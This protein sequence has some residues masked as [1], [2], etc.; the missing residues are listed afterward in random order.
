MIKEA[1]LFASKFFLNIRHCEGGTTEV[2][3]CLQRI[4]SLRCAAFAMTL[5]IFCSVASAQESLIYDDALRGYK[6]ALNLFQQKNYVHAKKLFIEFIESP[7]HV[8]GNE[9]QTLKN[10]AR[11]YAAF[12][13]LEL[14]QPDAEKLLLDMAQ[15]YDETPMKRLGYYYMGKYYFREKNYAEA[16]IW[17]EKTEIADLSNEDI[18]EYK[19]QLAYCYFY[20]KKLTEAG[21]LFKEI[22]NIKNKY[23]YPA[24]YYYGYIAFGNKEFDDAL[25]SFERLKDSKVYE[26]IIPY[27]ISQ[28]YYFKKQYKELTEY[29]API[30]N[31]TDLKYY[32]ELN[33]ILGQA[34]FDQQKYDK[35]VR[36]L[37]IYITQTGKARK[38]D[39]YQ[40]GYAHYK[41][42]D[43]KEAILQFEQLD[44]QKDTLGQ[45]ALYLLADCYMKSGN[46]SSA[47]S[48]FQKAAQME[49]DPFIA[50]HALF[51]YGKLSY[52]QGFDSEAIRAL[53]Q[54]NEKY[55]NGEDAEEAKEL[56]SELFLN[57]R[58]FKEA[59]KVIESVKNP[60][61]KVKK[62]YQEVAYFRGLEHYN[63]KEFDEGI[64]MFDVSLQNPSN[65]SIKALCYYWKGESNFS[66]QEYVT[67]GELY[68]QFLNLAKINDVSEKEWHEANAQ[69]G[70]GYSLFKQKK[71]GDALPY[72]NQCVAKCRTSSNRNLKDKVLSDALLRSADCSFIVKD[73]PAALTNYSEIIS[74]KKAGSDYAL[75]QKGMI[76]G[77]QGK[78][79]EKITAMQT[80]ETQYPTSIYLDDA[81]YETGTAQLALSKYQS[82]IQSF[83][84]IPEKFPTS[85]YVP[86]SYL[87]LGLTYYN[88]DDTK[89]AL[90]YYKRVISLYKNS[91]EAKE[92]FVA[93]KEIDAKLY[94]TLA[95]VTAS[96]KDSLIYL[97]AEKQYA[98]GKCDKA[99]AA[100]TEY[101][102]EFKE[103]YFRLP[104]HF[105]RGECHY[106]DKNFAAASQDYQFVIDAGK[107][108]YSEKALAKAARIAFEIDKD[109]EDAFEY[110]KLLLENASYKENIYGANLGLMR[111]A[112]QLQK[113]EDLKQYA[114]AVLNSSDAMPEHN[115]EAE[116]YLGKAAFAAADY[117]QAGKFFKKTAE[118]TTT[119]IGSE[120]KYRIAE[121]SFIKGNFT[122][123][124]NECKVMVEQKPTHEYWR[125]KGFI[126]LADNYHK[127]G[128]IFQAKA[129]LQ[130]IVDNYKGEE[131]KQIAQDKLNAILDEEKTKQKL[132]IIVDTGTTIEE[133]PNEEFELV[134]PVDN[135][136]EED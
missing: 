132:E 12:C 5:L 8:I 128:N 79:E 32:A 14:M 116:F 88:Q 38:E 40:L 16:I 77:L 80:I 13:A 105:Y 59:L 72:F 26:K 60:S 29:L 70:A 129:T 55:G 45:H 131:L 56:L 97:D 46:K 15:E 113:M 63:D 7:T 91:E 41:A 33:Q 108:L 44:N 104:A 133:D 28:V 83:K 48:A 93:I 125:V 107:N 85:A 90:D 21:K 109:Y 69:Y 65:A 51:N 23:Y 47:L 122:Q 49:F 110:F 86:K 61:A 102:A 126:L 123:S 74:A 27:Y 120:A 53:Q 3:P 67:A 50:E 10:N 52:E 2:I 37:T 130:S 75:Y 96:E 73:Y 99:I 31:D 98:S 25:Q 17:F 121:I 4:A 22:R 118:S 34:Y 136:D 19:F 100:F 134:V 106:S 89:T 111:C 117:E 36:H 57:T 9:N 30:I 35:A 20:K 114:T 94:T 66:K 11:F 115:I 124:M 64:R 95:P 6:E 62:A 101:L 68:L 82:A 1:R 78:M 39:V 87:K 18:A 24:N 92:A 42:E 84:K 81:V 58:N 135:L 76:L 127:L 54:Y 103:G 71:Y 112:F 119:V 43:Y